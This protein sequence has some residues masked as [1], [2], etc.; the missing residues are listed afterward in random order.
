PTSMSPRYQLLPKEL[1]GYARFAERRLRWLRWAY[2][3]INLHFQ[4]ELTRAQIPLQR[5]GKVIELLVSML[6]TAHHAASTRDPSQIR[7]AA[8]QCE[9]L[10]TRVKGMRLLTGLWQMD[11]LRRHVANVG[12]DIEKGQSALLDGVKPQAFAHPFAPQ[13]KPRKR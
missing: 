3:G 12:E 6:A 1:A 2:L 5:L 4:L 11:R 13:E 9:Q 7:L 8:L 10:M